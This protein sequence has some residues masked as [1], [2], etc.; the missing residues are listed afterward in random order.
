[1]SKDTHGFVAWEEHIICHERGNRVVHF[2]LKDTF[3]DLVLA[4]VGT[5]RSIR[6]MMYVV[7]DEFLN[8][9]G[10]ERFINASTKW[11]ARREVVDWLSSL[12]VKCRPPVDFSSM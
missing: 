3:G 10:S 2:Y 11:R 12:V 6:H 4:V 1:M 9:Y 7:S 8:A 5:E